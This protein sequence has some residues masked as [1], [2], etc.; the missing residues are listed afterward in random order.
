MSEQL[1]PEGITA[2]LTPILWRVNGTE[3]GLEL[4][5]DLDTESLKQFY[6]FINKSRDLASRVIIERGGMP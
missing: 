1:T 4:L 6:E 3:E 2:F 5:R